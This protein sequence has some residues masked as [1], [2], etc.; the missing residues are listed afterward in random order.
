MMIIFIEG[1]NNKGNTPVITL[2]KCLINEESVM[3]RKINLFFQLFT[4][5]N[6][7]TFNYRKRKVKKIFSMNEEIWKILLHF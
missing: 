1:L 4:G 2:K 3:F 6:V 5:K 7:N